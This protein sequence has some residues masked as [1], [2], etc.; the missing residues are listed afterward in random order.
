MF[1]FELDVVTVGSEAILQRIH[2]FHAWIYSKVNP[3]I[4]VFNIVQLLF[5]LLN[6][7]LINELLPHRLLQLVVSFLVFDRGLR[8]D[9]SSMRMGDLSTVALRKYL[10]SRIVVTSRSERKVMYAV[11][12]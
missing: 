7:H 3:T 4:L 2:V 10:P 6:S 8:E 9:A 5:S 1:N 12:N 11:Q